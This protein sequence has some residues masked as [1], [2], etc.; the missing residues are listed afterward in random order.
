[1]LLI[2]FYNRGQA[3]ANRTDNL[4]SMGDITGAKKL[5]NSITNSRTT[6]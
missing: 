2:Y 5:M 3:Q 6:I 4:S 1:M